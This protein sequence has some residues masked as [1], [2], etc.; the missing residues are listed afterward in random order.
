MVWIA[1]RLLELIS[2]FGKD[3]KFNAYIE[4]PIAFFYT[5]RKLGNEKKINLQASK[6]ITHLEKILSK[7]TQNSILKNTKYY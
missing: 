7:N 2:E 5:T 3:A 1:K 4:K 6:N